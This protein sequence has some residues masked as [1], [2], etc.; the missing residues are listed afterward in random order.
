MAGTGNVQEFEKIL[1]DDV[2]KL[3]VFNPAGL[4]AAHNAAARNKTTILALIVRYHGGKTMVVEKFI[5]LSLMICCRF[6]H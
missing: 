3:T 4:C 2:S 6:K 1:C 5:S